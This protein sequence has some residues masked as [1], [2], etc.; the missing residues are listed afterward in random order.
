MPVSKHTHC[1]PANQ[2]VGLDVL[3]LNFILGSYLI[4]QEH[5]GGRTRTAFVPHITLGT[6]SLSLHVAPR[7][8]LSKSLWI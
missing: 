4:A 6:M 8:F 2:C 3:G 1:I 5:R 7:L